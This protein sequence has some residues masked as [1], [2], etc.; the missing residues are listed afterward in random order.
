M[1]SRIALR[2][3]EDQALP[4][5]IGEVDVIVSGPA[6]VFGAE[7]RWP[8]LRGIPGGVPIE[9]ITLSLADGEVGKYDPA[10]AIGLTLERSHGVVGGSIE[11]VPALRRMV[12]DDEIGGRCRDGFGIKRSQL[13]AP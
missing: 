7:A 1:R 13:N 2:I 10:R 8:P 11:H 9:A 4:V 5:G 3:A 6:A 12:D